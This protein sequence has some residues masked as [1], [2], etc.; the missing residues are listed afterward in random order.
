VAT[1]SCQR[2]L[3]ATHDTHVFKGVNRQ[4]LDGEI[5]DL[6][7]CG[8]DGINEGFARGADACFV[9]LNEVRVKHP[10]ERYAIAGSYRRKNLPAKAVQPGCRI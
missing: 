4:E 8:N 9:D 10:V 5:V 7:I 2:A 6:D 3:Y 1:R